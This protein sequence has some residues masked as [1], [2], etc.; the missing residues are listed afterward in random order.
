MVLTIEELKKITKSLLFT[1]SEE[2]YLTLQQEF[3][4]ILEQM[5]LLGAIENLDQV[6]PLVFPIEN[7]NCGL[8]EDEVEKC[9]SVDEVLKNAKESMMDMVKVQKVVG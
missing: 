1:M 3:T 6:E 8:R 2:Q 4:L 9:L 7:E 5:K